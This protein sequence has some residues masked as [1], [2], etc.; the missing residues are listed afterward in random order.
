MSQKLEPLCV[1]QGSHLA[2]TIGDVVQLVIAQVKLF[3]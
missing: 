1:D 3:S 2:A